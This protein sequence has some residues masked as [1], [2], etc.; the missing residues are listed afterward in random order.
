MGSDWREQRSEGAGV[1]GPWGISHLKGV[2][3]HSKQ[4]MGLSYI[5]SCRCMRHTMFTLPAHTAPHLQVAHARDERPCVNESVE[6]WL[7][8]R[9]VVQQ[10][11]DAP[12]VGHHLHLTQKVGG[13]LG[14]VRGERV[15]RARPGDGRAKSMKGRTFLQ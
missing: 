10:A 8:A 7:V 5:R 12:F 9:Y 1:Q 15:G 14:G 2:L 6:G 13:G 4:Q 11:L 3:S